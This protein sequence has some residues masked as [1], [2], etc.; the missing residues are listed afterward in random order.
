MSGVFVGIT[1]ATFYKIV[2]AYAFDIGKPIHTEEQQE[3]AF[4]NYIFFA[5]NRN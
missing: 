3:P 4:I 5:T 1:D 2:R